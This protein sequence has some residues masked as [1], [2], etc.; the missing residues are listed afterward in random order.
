MCIPF[1]ESG[2]SPRFTKNITQRRFIGLLGFEFLTPTR[3]FDRLR[4]SLV[5]VF[6]YFEFNR[7]LVFVI[8][9]LY[10]I[11]IF[12]FRIYCGGK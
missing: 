8:W 4:P 7:Y 2:Q 11:S 5:S 6:C 9:L 12:E 3:L 1:Y 10:G